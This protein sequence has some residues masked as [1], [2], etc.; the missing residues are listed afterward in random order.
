MKTEW[1]ESVL[2]VA[3]LGDLDAAARSLRRTPAKV[4]W[5]I[6]Q[7][8]RE[9]EVM[10][11]VDDGG[12]ME[13][14]AAGKILLR[15]AQRLLETMSVAAVDARHIAEGRQGVLRLGLNDELATIRIAGLL[16]E[17]RAKLPDIEF[18]ITEM[19]SSAAATALRE[20]RIDL[21][22][23]LPAG[24]DTSELTLQ[25]L[26]QETWQAVLP[27]GSPLAALQTVQC[28]DLREYEIILPHPQL[29]PCGH[30]LIRAAF[31]SAGITPRVA[32]LVMG[33]A[34]M[35]TM[36]DA[37]VGI[38]FVPASFRLGNA[39]GVPVPTQRPFDAPPM[40]I[41]AAYHRG[42]PAGIAM[43]ALR[44]IRA[45]VDRHSQS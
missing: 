21:A 39:P 11:F 29:S 36:T 23:M 20:H 38:T 40:M 10:M 5:H 35:L 25:P 9:F 17:C 27:P 1:F 8:E 14:T 31:E 18:N 26:W 6:T 33:R 15:H 4:R 28:A 32:A 7:L 42:N 3:E 16:R 45:A 30:D 12:R 43:Q 2:K 24:A 34:T 37:G 19:T 41:S 22:L 13:S 44:V